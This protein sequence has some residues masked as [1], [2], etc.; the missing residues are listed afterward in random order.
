MALINNEE[1]N[2]NDLPP[3]LALDVT[4]QPLR[5]ITYKDS[6]YYASKGL[7][8]WSPTETELTIFG[9]KRRIDGEQSTLTMNTIIALNGVSKSKLHSV[10][11]PLTNRALF[12]RDKNL[13]GYC[14][15]EFV[16]AKLTRDH[17]HPKSRGGADKWNNVVTA[18]GGCNRHKSD[19][20]LEDTNME[21]LYV[22]YTPSRH[23]WLILQNRKILADQ[24]EFLMKGV[25]K[26]S[27]LHA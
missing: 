4:G 9:G 17:I 14:G 6:C 25:P 15:R 22:P 24:L 11:P 12:R 20:V 10:V 18:C 3:I 1:I 27:R 7:V 19:R 23:E 8:T 5:W 2:I 26:T 16:A 13:C 21:L